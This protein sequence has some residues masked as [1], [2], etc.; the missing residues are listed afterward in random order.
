MVIEAYEDNAN[1][2]IE[3]I[4]REV[5]EAHGVDFVGIWHLEGTF[6]PGEPVVLV[7]VTGPHRDRVFEAL[8][9][10]VERYKREPAIFKKEVF[11]GGGG[12]WVSE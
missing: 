7:A 11:K 1:A 9:E 2:E 8:R 4:C 3:R 12:W 6:R 5:K 10:S